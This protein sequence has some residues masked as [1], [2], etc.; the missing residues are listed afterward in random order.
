MAVTTSNKYGKITVSDEA[1]AMCAYHAASECYGVAELVSKG[2]AKSIASLFR[3]NKHAVGIRVRT[4]DNKI[5]IE[6]SVL[7]KEGVQAD[8]VTESLRSVVSYSVESFTG[9]RVMDVKVNVLGTKV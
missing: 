2:F 8:A 4:L 6:I 9:M 1:V 3:K 5:F 7:L